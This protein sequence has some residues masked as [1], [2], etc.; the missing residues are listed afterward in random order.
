[1]NGESVSRRTLSIPV[2]GRA[3]MQRKKKSI[4]AGVDYPQAQTKMT[5][6]KYQLSSVTLVD[7]DIGSLFG[8]TRWHILGLFQ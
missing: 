2:K 8:R 1:M 6:P 4:S 3:Q 7:K 5:R